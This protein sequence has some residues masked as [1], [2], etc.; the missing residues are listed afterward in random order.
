MI[1]KIGLIL[2]ILLVVGCTNKKFYLED[3]YYS[4]GKYINISLTEYNK[5]KNTNYV[6]FTYNSYCQFSKPCD[7]VFET[8]MKKYHISFLSMPYETFKETNLHD[9]VKY[10]PSVI[11]VKKGKIIAYLDAEKDEDIEIYQDSQ[12]FEKWLSKYIYLER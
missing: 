10:A 1:K 5:I 4:D 11:I 8:T 9:K 7:Q 2:I 3:K 6:L 12:K